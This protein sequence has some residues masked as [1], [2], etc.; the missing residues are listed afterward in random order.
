MSRSVESV[1]KALKAGKSLEKHGLTFYRSAAQETKSAKGKEVF[2]S[3]QRD[4]AMHLRLIQRQI[5]SL[6]EQGRW[7]ELPETTGASVD[8]SIDIFPEGRLGLEKAVGADTDDAE[9]LVLAMEFETRGYDMYR[10]EAATAEA[11]EARAMYEF[12]ASQERTHFDLLMA[13]WEAMANAGSWAD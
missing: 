2:E 3:L 10:Q 12:L 13:N 6:A 7:V 4:E 1:L 11:P 8:L 5:D 9:A